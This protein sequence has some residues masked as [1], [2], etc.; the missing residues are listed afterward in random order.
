MRDLQLQKV[1]YI[2]Y[3]YQD[4][5]GGGIWNVMHGLSA[6]MSAWISF[7]IFLFRWSDELQCFSGT[8]YKNG[9]EAFALKS[10]HADA[11]LQLIKESNY[12]VVHFMHTG[13]EPY[14]ALNAIV[15]EKVSVKKIYSCHS[16]LKYEQKI[17]PSRIIDIQYESYILE[18]V[19]IIH[20]LNNSSRDWLL[21]CYPELV[22]RSIV[23]IGNGIS[24]VPD[25]SHKFQPN[26]DPVVLCITRWSQGKGIEHLLD[27]IPM[28]LSE[29]PNTKFL[30]FGKKTESWEYNLSEYI[31]LIDNRCRKLDDAIK[32][33]GWVGE[34]E[35]KMLYSYAD[36]C[37]VP[38]ELEYF[39]Y[40]VLEPM[41]YGKPVVC[42]DISPHNEILGDQ[43][44]STRYENANSVSMA[45]VIK[46][47]I[48]NQ[49]LARNIGY[50]GLKRAR[51]IF[52]WNL[53]VADYC[54][55]YQL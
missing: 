29:I 51:E 17:R 40:S 43:L 28:V 16:I 5:K 52:D 6:H 10:S 25:L 14:E 15:S 21:E 7:D 35:K 41:A 48:V 9:V 44:K 46:N 22:D 53:V 38:S 13:K 3:E 18:H 33:Y 50:E 12:T 47:L 32:V 1:L 23:I 11:I 34:K 37:V 49:K 54:R 30:L 31:N 26:E 42:S 20:V 55:M 36:I 2:T 45:N 24:R 19:D 4:I 39:P 8:L 27:A